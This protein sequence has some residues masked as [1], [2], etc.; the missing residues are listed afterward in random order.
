MGTDPC[1]CCNWP[2]NFLIPNYFANRTIVADD[3]AYCIV[4]HLVFAMNVG[5]AAVVTVDVDSMAM[6][7]VVVDGGTVVIVRDYYCYCYLHNSARGPR[8]RNQTRH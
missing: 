7:V 1:C 8:Y 4:V 6:A 5:M 2:R 3:G